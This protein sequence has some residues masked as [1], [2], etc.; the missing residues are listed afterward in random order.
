LCLLVWLVQ[1]APLLLPAQL[2]QIP[3]HIF[4]VTT[5]LDSREEMKKGHHVRRRRWGKR[6]EGEEEEEVEE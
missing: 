4:Q 6:L 1:S 5:H 2:Q 3:Q